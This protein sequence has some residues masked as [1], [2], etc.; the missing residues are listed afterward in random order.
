M[1]FD[2][3]TN[4]AYTTVATAPS[5][6][7]S[8]TSL[9]VAAATGTR[10]PAVPFN[11]VIWPVNSQPLSSNA[12]IVRVTNISTDTLTITRTQESTSARSIIAGD[13]IAACL[14]AKTITDTQAGG[15]VLAL[16][17]GYS[18]G[19]TLKGD[20][21]SAGSLTLS[22][23][24]HA[25]KG[26]VYLN[27]A[28]T[29]GLDEA[30]NRLFIGN[31]SPGS[32]QDIFLSKSVAG[33][34]GIYGQNSNS[35]TTGT[36]TLVLQNSAASIAYLRAFSSGYSGSLFGATLASK[37]LL[38]CD[39]IGT[40]SAREMR[41]GTNATVAILINSSNRVAVAAATATPAGGSSDAVLL[42][43]TTSGFGI[44][45]GSGAPTVSAAAGSLYVRTDNAGANLRLYSNTTG[46][47]TWAAITSA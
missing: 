26:K 21:A 25:T 11:A 35:G 10:F 7:T 5:P 47:T 16:L 18:G 36:C 31:A 20:T 37:G 39:M 24:A 22:S 4:F 6:A 33:D 46:S 8:G 44:Y 40:D 32:S 43:G 41:L 15:G 23:T 14:T 19:Q 13:Q 42:F 28:Q 38:V 27:S 2:L 9:V 1:A 29:T 3:V 30:N 12:E 34:V 45:F 17:A